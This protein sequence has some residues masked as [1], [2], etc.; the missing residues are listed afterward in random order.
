MEQS[1]EW[2]KERSGMDIVTDRGYLEAVK[3][4]IVQPN[5]KIYQGALDSI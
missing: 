1:E 5:V 4:R 3:L 2:N